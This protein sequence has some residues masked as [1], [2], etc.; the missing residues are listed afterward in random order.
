MELV[1]L[2]DSRPIGHLLKD[3]N[4]NPL[5]EY[6]AEWRAN[7]DAIPLSLSLP[8][9]SETHASDTVASVLWGLLPDNEHTLQR[10]A[11]KFQV[12]A[13]NPL[14]LLAHI[15]ED[16]AG[17]V[18]FVRPDRVA[19]WTAGKKDGVQWLETLDVEKRLHRLRQDSGATR[20]PDDVGQFSLAGAQPKI[21]LLFRDG[22]WGIPSG[23]VPTTHILKPPT[24]EFDGF[25][26][27]EHFCFRLARA[28]DLPA[29]ASAVARFGE[30]IAICVERY[31]RIK[32]GNDLIRV[33]Q[34]DFCQALGVHPQRKYQNQGGPSPKDMGD[35][36][37]VHSSRP[38]DDLETLFRA[39]AFNWLLAG[40]DAHAKN[41]S[42]LLGGRGQVRLAPLYDLLSALPYPQLNKRKSPLAM[43]VG[44]H[45]RWWDIAARDWSSLARE[46]KLDVDFA[47]ATL[48]KM[49]ELLPEKALACALAMAA[50]GLTHPLI[51][52][53]VDEIAQTAR[54][55]IRKLDS[56]STPRRG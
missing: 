13:R 10:W 20:E 6:D 25:A 47:F 44:S 53:L 43:K 15:G 17:A 48:Q 56:G 1:A 50:D 2:L 35:L 7:P 8:I 9:A 16:C 27:N 23:R 40:T 54:R 30:E 3:R 49:A 28:L 32:V 52:R 19:A 42:L 31:D 5:L 4:G 36:I 26:E 33:H 39:L 55:C 34:E 38:R 22:R 37:R 29:A 14:A 21:A 45:Y 46:L 12:S 24:G 51:P 18:S 41:Y 11:A